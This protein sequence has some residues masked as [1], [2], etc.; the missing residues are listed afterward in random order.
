VL[1][2][3]LKL[4]EAEFDKAFFAYVE[5]KARPLFEASKSETNLIA[6]LAKAEVLKML[7]SQDTFA[8][9][10]RAAELYAADGDIKTAEIHFRR[11]IELY[12][13]FTGEGN[14]Y[15][16]LAKILDS[17]GE[18][19]KAA[20]VLDALV[21]VDENNLDVLKEIA[22]LRQKS[23]DNTRAVQALLMSFYISPFDYALH[24]TAGELSFSA[25]NYEQALTEF[26]V[27]LALQPPNI[28]EANYNVATAFHALGRQQEAKRSVLNALE[29]APR[30][31]KAQELLLRIVGQ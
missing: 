12:P 6:S 10:A 18:P 7:E 30:Y 5:T 31:E 27:A 21:R 22:R 11:A 14:A 25:K 23:G 1:R 4:T 13:Y 8:L 29:A 17:G 9:R 28:A 2:Q 20:D 16:A 19:G 15:V 3:A 26:Q 24:T